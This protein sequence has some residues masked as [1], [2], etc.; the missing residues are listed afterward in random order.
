[1]SVVQEF[2][3]TYLKQNIFLGYILLQLPCINFVLHTMLIRFLK[4]FSILHQYC[5]QCVCIVQWGCFCSSLIS[6][7]PGTLLRFSP[8]DFDMIYIYCNWV[9]TRW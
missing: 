6:C 4:M 9:A 7:F 8:K 5:P 2:A 3:I 1:M